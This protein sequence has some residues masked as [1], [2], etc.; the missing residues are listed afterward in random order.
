MKGES[1]KGRKRQ[2]GLEGTKGKE[3]KEQ[4]EE[5]ERKKASLMCHSLKAKGVGRKEKNKKK[6]RKD[7]INVPEEIQ[8][9]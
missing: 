6:G 8:E 4:K 5:K 7:F 2:K 9:L 3:G 1:K